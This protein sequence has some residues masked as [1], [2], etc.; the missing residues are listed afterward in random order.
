[1]KLAILS[2]IHSNLEALA[3][4][5][6]DLHNNAEQIDRI[7]VTGDIVGYGPNPNECCSIVRYL[8]K[9]SPSLK[10]AIEDNING[11]DIDDSDKSIITKD[12]LSLQKTASVV[13]GNHDKE[14]IG[15]PSYVSTM[16]T[17]AAKAAKWTSDILARE[18]FKFLH[19]LGFTKKLGSLSIEMVHSTPVYPRGWEYPKN[20]GVLSYNTLRANITFAGH[21]HCPAAYLYKNNLLDATPTVFVP[22]DQFDIR[23]MLIERESSERAEEFDIVL[24]PGH[25]YYINPGSVGQPRDG[26]PKASYMVYDTDNHRIALKKAEYNTEAVKEKI[27]KAK[28]PRDLANRIV[29]GV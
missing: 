28:L 20:A 21:T 6:L 4:V 2:D 27:I 10:T 1:M 22:V 12:I 25:K 23:L 3:A 7:L 24:H 26:V 14:V 19:S 15:Q 29:K 18:N 17:S 8:Q 13:V 5:F 11:I 9:G 16:A